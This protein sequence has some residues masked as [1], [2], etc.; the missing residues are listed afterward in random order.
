MTWACVVTWVLVAVG[1]RD[2]EARLS[3]NAGQHRVLSPGDAVLAGRPEIRKINI[4]SVLAKNRKL[5]T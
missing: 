3:V 2:H 5:N 4:L 1:L